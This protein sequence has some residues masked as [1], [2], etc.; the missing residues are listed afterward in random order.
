[1]EYMVSYLD[2]IA[3]LKLSLRLHNI[4]DTKQLT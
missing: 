1:M 4:N 3:E 2:D